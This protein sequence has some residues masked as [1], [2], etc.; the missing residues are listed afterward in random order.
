MIDFHSHILPGI[1]DGADGVETSLKMLRKSKE[2]GVSQ[3]VATPHFYFNKMTVEA[4][5]KNRQKAYETLMNAIGE[6]KLPGIHLGCE[7]HLD[8]QME[9]MKD[10]EKLCLEGTNVILLEMPFDLWQP[11]INDVVYHIIA[12]RKLIPVIAHV[13]RYQAMLKQFER[14]ETLLSMEVIVQLNADAFLSWSMNRNLKKIIGLN[15]PIVLGSDMHNLTDR[16]SRMDAAGKKIEK[17]FGSWMLQSMEE[18]AARLLENR[19]PSLF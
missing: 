17:K 5:L 16:Q 7:V 9:D 19:L 11:W 13:D 2:Q 14:L 12:Q 1:D 8:G 15:R 4:F 6:E 3:I 18:N 10:L